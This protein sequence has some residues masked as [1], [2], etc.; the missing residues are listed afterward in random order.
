MIAVVDVSGVMEIL[1]NKEKAAQFDKVLQDST[2]VMT[3]DL[4]VSKLTNA[5]RKYHSARMR[6]KDE[7]VKYIQQGLGIIN[8]FIDSKELW[9][10]AFAEGINNKHS[11]YDMFYMIAARRN[12]GILVTSDSKLAAICKKNHVQVCC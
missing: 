7:C 10:E 12:G 6:T 11:V 4:Y 1:L 9:K 2:L 3:P 8:I 5:F